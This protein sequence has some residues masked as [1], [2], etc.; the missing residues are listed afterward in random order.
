[1]AVDLSG[2][3]AVLTPKQAVPPH[4]DSISDSLQGARYFTQLDFAQA[5]FSVP[6]AEESQYLTTIATRRGL[7]S[8]KRMAN[9]LQVAPAIFCQ[10]INY[11]S[12]TCFGMKC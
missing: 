2:V 1:M 6:I 5:Y 8:S 12:V 4:I 11:F 10:L 7:F 3:N 9:G